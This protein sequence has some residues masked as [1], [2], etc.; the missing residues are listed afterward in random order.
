MAGNGSV[1][2]RGGAPGSGSRNRRVVFE[3]RPNV[4]TSGQ[5]DDDNIGNDEGEFEEMFRE[6]AEF[7]FLRG[8]EQI[9]SQ[10]LT[11]IQPFVMTIPKSNRTLEINSAWRAYEP[12][13]LGAAPS[14]SGYINIRSISEHGNDRKYLDLL[15]DI[16]A[17]T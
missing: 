12:D 17:A 2:T 16:G 15:C 11:G 4:A 5:P 14:A 10:R 8:G 7:Q 13:G 3:R 6:W 1:R 9:M